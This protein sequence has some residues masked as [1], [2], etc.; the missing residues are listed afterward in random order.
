[1]SMRPWWGPGRA[2]PILTCGQ[3]VGLG[4]PRVAGSV[5]GLLGQDVPP[6]S[7]SR[8]GRVSLA[9]VL[10]M[11][12]GLPFMVRLPGVTG[13]CMGAVHGPC[14]AGTGP[15]LER[16]LWERSQPWPIP[17]RGCSTPSPF[18]RKGLKRR[19]ILQDRAWVP[20]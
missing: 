12:L 15:W 17:S 9:A 5:L 8:L 20:G 7:S 11:R 6:S 2:G 18:P 13:W 14:L 4:G 16:P 1:M 19:F 10:R 3:C